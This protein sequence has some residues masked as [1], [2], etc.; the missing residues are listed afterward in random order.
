M[1]LAQLRNR[2]IDESSSISVA[3]RA[4]L[5]HLGADLL[6]LV[7]QVG[8]EERPMIVAVVVVAVA[9]RVVR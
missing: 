8:V 7:L 4:E 6:V 1:S 2:R 9:V 5:G 3:L